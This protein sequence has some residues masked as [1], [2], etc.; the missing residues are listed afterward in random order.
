[1]RP[2][3]GRA[4]EDRTEP[5]IERVDVRSRDARP[6]ATAGP[7]PAARVS[8]RS[9]S[10]L[11][12]MGVWTARVV[13]DAPNG[14]RAARSGREVGW[15]RV[16]PSA[17]ARAGHPDARYRFRRPSRR[18]FRPVRDRGPRCR[19]PRRTGLVLD[20]RA[21]DKVGPLSRTSRLSR[22]G[23]DSQPDHDAGRSCRKGERFGQQSRFGKGE[24][25]VL[26]SA[27]LDV[28]V[29]L[30]GSIMALAAICGCCERRRDSI[31]IARGP[32]GPIVNVASG[33]DAD[34]HARARDATRVTR[35]GFGPGGSSV[36]PRRVVRR[37][38]CA[39]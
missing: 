16:P 1:M 21:T 5:R 35:G 17:S 29:R 22:P 25:C 2:S 32:F 31:K 13:G 14:V 18:S 37:G 8:R 11:Y 6:R 7:R 28:H 38:R 3:V 4:C 30:T 23:A 27:H 34:T 10:T 9:S 24:G 20:T 26:A 12:V 19:N 39:V 36:R 15:R 33:P